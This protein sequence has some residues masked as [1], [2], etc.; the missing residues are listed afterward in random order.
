MHQ[1]RQEFGTAIIFITHDLALAAQL[2]DEVLVLLNGKVL[3]YGPASIVLK[4]PS[5][6]Y[7]KALLRS[8]PG[9]QSKGFRLP[10][11]ADALSPQEEQRTDIPLPEIK[12]TK[13]PLLQVKNLRVWFPAET[14]VFGTATRFHRAVEDVTF[15][16][17]TGEVLALVGETGSGKSTLCRA[18]MGLQPIESGKIIFDGRDLAHL[19]PPGWRNI[20]RQIQ[21]IF[22]DPNTS[23]NPHLTIGE[24]IREPLR[25]H[26]IVPRKEAA[27]EASR[28]LSLVHLPATALNHYPHQ[29]SGADRLRIV[30]ARALA[31]RP[32]LLIFDESLSSLDNS[33]QAELLNLLKDLQAQLHLSYLFISHDLPAVHYLAD[34]VMVMRA[35]KIV[36]A[37]TAEAVLRHPQQEYTRNLV[38]AIP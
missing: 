19:G 6:A 12:I 23:L 25:A 24:A 1:L 30:I 38:A 32:R 13:D 5:Q 27:S 35:G 15:T 29:F 16:M 34:R 9:P 21:M 14:N 4:T 31:L 26:S 20:R 10:T 11:I 3:E 17:Q 33:T 28:L 22:H 2:A 8:R 37:G 7:T 18:L 36:E